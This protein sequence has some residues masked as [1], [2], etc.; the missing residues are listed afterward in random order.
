MCLT[1]SLPFPLCV[2]HWQ[3]DEDDE[4]DN[5]SPSHKPYFKFQGGRY[6]RLIRKVSLV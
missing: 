1:N 4:D 2:L 5:K 6:V 3:D